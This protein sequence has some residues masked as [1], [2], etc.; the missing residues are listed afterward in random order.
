MP[1]AL[2]MP[3]LQVSSYARVVCAA[4]VQFFVIRSEK[5]APGNILCCR[6]TKVPYSWPWEGM[7]QWPRLKQQN[8]AQIQ[9][10]DLHSYACQSLRV[11]TLMHHQ[12]IRRAIPGTRAV[13]AAELYILANCTAVPCSIPTSMQ[14]CI[15]LAS[16]SVPTV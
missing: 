12:A 4:T 10:S 11:S 6:T 2:A 13:C 15:L 14:A 1:E 9:R 3:L 16:H 5:K 7:Q 8:H